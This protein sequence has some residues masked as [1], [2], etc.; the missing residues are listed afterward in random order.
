MSLDDA[1]LQFIKD[2]GITKEDVDES[3]ISIEILKEIK[4][5]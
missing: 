4:Y 1:T 2:M 3:G 5:N